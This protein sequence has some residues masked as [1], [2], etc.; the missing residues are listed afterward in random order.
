MNTEVKLSFTPGEMEMLVLAK[1][2]M[3]NNSNHDPMPNETIAWIVEQ[4]LVGKLGR[5]FYEARK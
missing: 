3:R 2:E 5:E 4:Y 1:I